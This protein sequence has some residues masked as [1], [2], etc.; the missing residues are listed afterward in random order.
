[1]AKVVGIGGVFFKSEDPGT[2]GRW[3]QTHLG[4]DVQPWGGAAMYFNK[5]DRPGIGYTVWSPFAADTKYFE[6]SAKPFMINLRV[7]DLDAVLEQL[8]AAGASVLD[9]HEKGENGRFGY[10]MD[11]EGN[12]LELWQQSDDDPYVPK[13]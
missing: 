4:V 5:R 1:M 12:L 6:P 11:P 7:D 2:L 8:R 10:V 3:Y 13:E 9:R